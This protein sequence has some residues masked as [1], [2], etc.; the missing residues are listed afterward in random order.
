[1]KNSK[2]RRILMLLACA[3]LLVCLSVG[4]TLAY[5]SAQTEYVK[6]T[7]VAGEGIEIDLLEGDVYEDGEADTTDTNFGTHRP[8]YDVYENRVKIN[9]YKLVP[10]WEYDKDPIVYVKAKSGNCYIFVKV[11]NELSDLEEEDVATI[12]DQI[13]ANGW[14]QLKDKD[15]NDV[16]NVYYYKDEVNTSEALQQFPVFQKF[17]TEDSLTSV[18]A[19]D[20]KTITVDAYAIQSD[21]FADAAAAWTAQAAVWQN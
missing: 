6:N 17:T 12:A 3:V 11:V 2:L 10:G 16:T 19:Y 21:G 7:F 8:G 9:N 14:I 15:G 18:T 5:L 1:M 13:T 20:G 4:A